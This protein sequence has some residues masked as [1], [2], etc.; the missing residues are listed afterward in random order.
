MTT[1]TLDSAQVRE[2]VS[3]KAI[4]AAAI[5]GEP[6]GWSV[7]LRHGRADKALAAQRSGRV[8][9][10]RSLDRCVAYLKDELGIAVIDGIDARRYEPGVGG[11]KRP[12][13]ARALRRAHAAAE[14][15]AWFRE[16]VAL[17]VAQADR[18]EVVD[19]AVIVE[20]SRRQRERL[21][22]AAKARAA[23][24]WPC[25]SFGRPARASTASKR[26]STSP[27][28]RRSPRRAS[29]TTSWLKPSDWP[30][31]RSLADRVASAAHGNL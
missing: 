14:Y 5:V 22:A 17:G 10:W 11:A 27:P 4:R 15:D 29:W 28:T 31:I 13:R 19:H 12:D 30:S 1:A 21:L 26:S 9:L 8:R 18:G 25:V 2:F 7:R 20:D 16:Q 24:R 23:Q 3:N 6:G